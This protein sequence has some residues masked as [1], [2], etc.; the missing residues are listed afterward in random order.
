ASYWFANYKQ[1]VKETQQLSEKLQAAD[2][3]KDE[4]LA[5]TSHELRNP[6][7]GIVSIAQSVL[8][9]SGTAIGAENSR[10]LELLVTIGR[11]M[12]FMLSDL[13]DLSR[14]KNNAIQLSPA[15]QS[16]QA[17]TNAVFDMLRFLVGDKPIR[18]E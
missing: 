2:H 1:T 9:R 5:N 3:L 13:M 18:L 17:I 11:R 4:F 16:V 8:E 12:S 14:L 6:L 15:P 10:N 7:H